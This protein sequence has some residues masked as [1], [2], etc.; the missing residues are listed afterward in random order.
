MDHLL[1]IYKYHVSSLKKLIYC[2]YMNTI[3]ISLK[4]STSVG[5]LIGLVM[6]YIAWLH[7]T[8]CEIHCDGFIDWIYLFL[9]WLSWFIVTGAAGGICISLLLYLFKLVRRD[10]NA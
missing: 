4:I 2:S 6:C 7:N 5:A 9:I 10:K 8:Q 3:A 1:K